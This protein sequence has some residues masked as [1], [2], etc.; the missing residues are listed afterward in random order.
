MSV[1]L[2]LHL[3]DYVLTEGVKIVLLPGLTHATVQ[4]LHCCMML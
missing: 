2:L 1:L 3:R 4:L